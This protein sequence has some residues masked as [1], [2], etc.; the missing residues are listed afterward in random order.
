MTA[1]TFGSWQ[2]DIHDD[3]HVTLTDR[4]GAVARLRYERDGQ[5]RY[6]LKEVQIE[7]AED[8]ALSGR[9]WRRIP[10]VDLERYMG[11]R[12]QSA[13]PPA[14]TAPEGRLTDEF[15]KTVADAYLW[16]TVSGRHPAPSIAEMAKVPV[17]RVHRWV[18]EARKRGFLP[19]SR[20]GRAG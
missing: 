5:G 20:P 12:Q 16:M 2:A 6:A 9:C 7:G 3:G 18:C 14:V 11:R 15:L 17:S 10:F 4:G 8:V 1:I 13:E 19:P